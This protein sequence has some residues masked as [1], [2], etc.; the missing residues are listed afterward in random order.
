MWFSGLR[1]AIAFALSLNLDMELEARHVIVTTTLVLVVFTTMFLG[2]GTMPLMKFMNRGSDG[3]RQKKDQPFIHFSKVKDLGDTLEVVARLEGRGSS[4]Q[5]QQLVGD[6]SDIQF[7]R[8]RVRLKGFARLDEAILKP[9]FI[10]KFNGEEL[11]EGQTQMKI[12][13][14]QWFDEVNKEDINNESNNDTGSED[15]AN[16][17]D[18]FGE[19]VTKT[20]KPK[21]APKKVS[22]N[23][24]YHHLNPAA[25][26]SVMLDSTDEEVGSE[27]EQVIIDQ[28]KF[29]LT[30]SL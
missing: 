19:F 16:E 25:I 21:K 22:D 12:L 28:S 1:G 24:T 26:S 27:D 15:Q 11:K 6:A 4:K 14:K 30:T 3:S 18:S 9:F 17:A 10:R 7:V 23:K 13:T 20:K 8:N 2:G 5:Q 29:S